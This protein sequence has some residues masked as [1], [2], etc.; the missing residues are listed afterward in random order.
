MSTERKDRFYLVRTDGE[1]AVPAGAVVRALPDAAVDTLDALA[2]GLSEIPVVKSGADA[3]ASEKIV[4]VA[5]LAA[6]YVAA[7]RKHSGDQAAVF[8]ELQKACGSLPLSIRRPN[9]P[10]AGS[11]L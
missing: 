4:H 3:N 6:K 1:I 5:Q 10:I 9:D 7:R 8:L 11:L 2:K